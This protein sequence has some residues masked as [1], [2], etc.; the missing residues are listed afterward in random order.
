MFFA[1][2]EELYISYVKRMEMRL[3]E[4]GCRELRLD[5]AGPTYAQIGSLIMPQINL[6]QRLDV[7]LRVLAY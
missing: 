3:G 5:K 6:W 2:G 7:L 4:I 1:D